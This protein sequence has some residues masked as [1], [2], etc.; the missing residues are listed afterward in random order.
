MQQNAFCSRILCITCY[1][2]V[3]ICIYTLRGYEEKKRNRLH[4]GQCIVKRPCITRNREESTCNG[5][6]WKRAP[7]YTV[8]LF[9]FPSLLFS[10]SLFL[11]LSMPTIFLFLRIPW[12]DESKANL[13]NIPTYRRTRTLLIAPN[14]RLL[15]NSSWKICY[16]YFTIVFVFPPLKPIFN[17]LNYDK[18]N[19]LSFFFLISFFL[20]LSREIQFLKLCSIQRNKFVEVKIE[21]VFWGK[22]NGALLLLER[23]VIARNGMVYTKNR[24]I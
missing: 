2:L 21:S 6:E 8:L 7:L 4:G 14:T 24:R 9:F 17:F 18:N 1:I 5:I 20:I 11:V 12:R 15:K 19:F 10:V 23:V 16:K 3:Y 22:F 13:R